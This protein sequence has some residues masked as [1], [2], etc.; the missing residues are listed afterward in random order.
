MNKFERY[1]TSTNFKENVQLREGCTIGAA[2][3][4]LA[5]YE[6]SGY[7]PMCAKLASDGMYTWRLS[8][9]GFV[10][11]GL[12]M[13]LTAT[14]ALNRLAEY[15]DTCMTPDGFKRIISEKIH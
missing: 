6:E 13:C 3:C 14:D 12:R 10:D 1:T 15:E 8:S 11:T 9:D 5:D 7:T 2:I 4:Q